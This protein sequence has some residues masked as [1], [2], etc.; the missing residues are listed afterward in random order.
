MSTQGRLQTDS[1]V[2]FPGRNPRPRLRLFCLP[3]AGG[4]ALNFR[5][6]PSYLPP[7]V[8][9]CAVQLPGRGGRIGTPPFTEAQAL[10]RSAAPALL[11]YM[12]VPFAFFGHSM[13]GL[14]AFELARHLRDRG[15]PR[16]Q[17]LFISGRRAPQVAD[18]SPH[19]YNLPE[20]EFI[21][22]VARLNGTPRE[23]LE[24]EELMRLVTPLLRSDFS[25]C[26]TY[27]YVPGPPLDCPISVFGGVRDLEVTREHLEGWREQTVAGITLRMFPG[28]HFFIHSEQEAFLHVLSQELMRYARPSV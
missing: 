12:D 5:T 21:E 24:N 3:Y 16:P 2:V 4:S 7:H 1:W 11:P 14:L 15:G 10:V 26:Q 20:A 9:V 28:D 25:V 6:W 19:T 17:H 18:D 8:E 13:G 23:V 22:E 27:E